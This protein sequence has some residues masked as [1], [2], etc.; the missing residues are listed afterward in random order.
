MQSTRRVRIG[1][2]LNQ[3][4]GLKR[5][6][7]RIVSLFLKQLS[8]LLGS[9]LSL[10]DSLRIIEKQKLD[11]KLSKSLSYILEDLDQ[12]ASVSEAFD[13]RREN[14]DPLTLAFIKSGDKS[15]KLSE[16][17]EVLSLHM[18]EDYEK[19]KQIKEAFIYPAILFLVTILVVIAMMVFVLPT[20]ASVFEES[21]QKLPLSTR[22]L[23][24]ISDF[25]V[26][27]GPFVLITLGLIFIGINLLR[28]SYQFRLKMD[29]FVF[30]N[31]LF[32]DFRH[33]NM[34]YQVASLISILRRGNID[35]IQSMEIIKDGFANV[36]LVE[37]FDLL[38]DDLVLGMPMSHAFDQAGIFSHLFIS[39]IEVGEGSGS[40]VEAME[41]TG[42]YLANEYL[43]RLKKMSKMAE[44]ILIMLMALV[45][46]FVV[47][48]VALPMFDSVNNIDF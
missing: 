35:I 8:L 40:M 26:T 29:E 21:G 48:S 1:K 37:K 10:D 47:F 32:R 44:P 9:G 5:I 28:K 41:K 16:I 24:G 22:I 42:D 3:E 25:F 27:K 17:L 20:F 14:F 18:T 38:I 12:G 46:G 34:E 7:Q 6:D 13:K 23:I 15:G 43:Y 11:K 4:I 30:K 19:R 36:Y 39:M 33:L 2:F 45:V 31:P